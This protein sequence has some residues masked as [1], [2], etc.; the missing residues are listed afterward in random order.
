[1]WGDDMAKDLKTDTEKMTTEIN[2]MENATYIVKD[3]K[4]VKIP[5]P[6]NG[7]GKQLIS[8]NDGKPCHG[9]LEQSF[10]I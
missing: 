6:P 5:T 7:F 3:G 8:W 10:K 4:L 9:V 1:M 2:L